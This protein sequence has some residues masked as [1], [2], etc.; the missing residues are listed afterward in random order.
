MKATIR[1]LAVCLVATIGAGCADTSVVV[2]EDSVSVATEGPAFLYS[3]K[4]LERQA[5]RAMDE[6]RKKACPEKAN[7]VDREKGLAIRACLTA[8][9]ACRELDPETDNVHCKSLSQVCRSSQSLVDRQ[10]F[11]GA[12]KEAATV[13]KTVSGLFP[14][15][16]FTLS[17]EADCNPAALT[18]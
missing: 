2:R 8:T 12:V 15:R 18:R 14:M 1:L 9:A 10:S 7:V 5:V 11:F 17:I 4:D 3:I 6:A 13:A 16:S